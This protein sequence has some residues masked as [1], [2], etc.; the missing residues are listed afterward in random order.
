MSLRVL[1]YLGTAF[2]GCTAVIAASETWRVWDL[3]ASVQIAPV[4]GKKK[5]CG[6]KKKKKA[7][8]IFFSVPWFFYERGFVCLF[9]FVT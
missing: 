2:L 4:V 6:M 1:P 5:V 8:F 9:V 7:S 3:T